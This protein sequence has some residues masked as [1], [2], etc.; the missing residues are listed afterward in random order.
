MA[1]VR[2][3]WTNVYV[4]H[5]K[6]NLLANNVS[7]LDAHLTDEGGW[8]ASR[9]FGPGPIDPLPTRVMCRIRTQSFIG[10][11]TSRTPETIHRAF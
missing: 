5:T 9:S 8:P 7:K 2:K 3:D 10:V 1:C 4:P 6:A 11:A